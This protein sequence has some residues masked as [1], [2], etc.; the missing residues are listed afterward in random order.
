MAFTGFTQD[1]LRFIAEN[2]LRNDT[3]WFHSHREVYDQ[4]LIPQLK[5]LVE[6]LTPWMHSL[7][8]GMEISPRIGRNIGRINRDLRFS[9]DKTIYNDH[10]WIKFYASGREDRDKLGF[11]WG[12]QPESYGGGV[13]MHGLS[14]DFMQAFRTRIKNN[15]DEFRTVLQGVYPGRGFELGGESYKKTMDPEV[16]S[17]WQIWSQF[18]EFYFHETR[19]IDDLVF[20]PGLA[21]H[22]R[23]QFTRLRPVYEYFKSMKDQ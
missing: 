23:E 18:K 10:M 1:C 13:G 15:P 14:S 5:A 19:P 6:E 2:H 20:S 7:D 21:E 17:E 12:L 9:R 22:I 16:P 3:A 4:V 8:P 11:F